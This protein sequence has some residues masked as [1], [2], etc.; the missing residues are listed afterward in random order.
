MPELFVLLNLLASSYMTGVIWFVQLVHYRQFDGVG[1][2]Q[3]PAYHARHTTSTGL[4]VAPLMLVELLASV[5]M[6][7]W[8]ARGVPVWVG[9][10]G[11]A[12]VALLW[13]STFFVQIPLHERLSSSFD[14]VAC[15]ALNT[16][17]W[18][19]TFAW[20]ARAGLMFYACWLVMTRVN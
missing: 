5:G 19:R 3:W 10:T 9:L 2:D 4:I 8:P 1:S 13:A 12:L 18:F 11:A 14:P 6:L 17:N 16:S 20:S 7:V 15:R